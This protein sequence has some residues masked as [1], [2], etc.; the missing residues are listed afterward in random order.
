MSKPYVK[1]TNP[2]GRVNVVPAAGNKAYYEKFNAQEKDKAKQYKIEEPTDEE[3]AKYFP[4]V[5]QATA[6]A[7]AKKEAQAAAEVKIAE[8]TSAKEESDKARKA[9]EVKAAELTAAK[10]KAEVE[11]AAA[12]EK[13][14]QLQKDLKKATAK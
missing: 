4:E 13:V 12:N 7:A 2:D 8:L 9:A 11:L 6:S 10:E 3:I 1:I 5:A 14:E